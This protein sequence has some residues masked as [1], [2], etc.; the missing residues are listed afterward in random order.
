[1]VNDNSRKFKQNQLEMCI[2]DRSVTF[3]MDEKNFAREEVKA[4]LLL[5][6]APVHAAEDILRSDNGKIKC[7]F[8]PPNT[9]ALIQPCLLYTSRCV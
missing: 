8:M 3:Q 1:M 5:D 9:S 6:N 4:V 2:R 7:L